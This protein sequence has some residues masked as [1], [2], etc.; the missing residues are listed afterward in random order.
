MLDICMC[1]GGKCPLREECYRFTAPALPDYQGYFTEVPW[2]EFE[3]NCEF[4][5]ENHDRQF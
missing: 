5:W 3:L 1:K 4:Y 2:D